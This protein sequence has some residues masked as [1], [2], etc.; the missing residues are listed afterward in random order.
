MRHQC[1]ALLKRSAWI[2]VPLLLACKSC[3][4][5]TDKS[6]SPGNRST[7]KSA[8][9]I[10]LIDQWL[11]WHAARQAGLRYRR[12]AWLTW[13]DR[14]SPCLLAGDFWI[15]CRIRQ[16]PNFGQ[17]TPRRFKKLLC[18]CSR[19]FA[20]TCRS[21]DLQRVWYLQIVR[22]AFG[23]NLQHGSLCFAAGILLHFFFC[24]RQSS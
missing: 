2:R 23:R 18:L 9:H 1:L 12:G 3:G 16:C 7:Q 5:V 4:R 17:V 15:C 19:L 6:S 10:Q 22:R 24:P 13:L 20:Q 11:K 14:L 21:N 8:S